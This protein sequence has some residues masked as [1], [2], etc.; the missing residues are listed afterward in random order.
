MDLQTN[1]HY[2][3]TI[4]RPGSTEPERIQVRYERRERHDDDL[5][6]FLVGPDRFNLGI[7]DALIGSD[8][9]IEPL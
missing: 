8:F 9:D 1:S 4:H 3:L 2:Q 6:H 5:V 7:P